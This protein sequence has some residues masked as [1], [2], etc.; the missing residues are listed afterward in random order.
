MTDAIAL[1]RMHSG[2]TD[3]VTPLLMSQDKTV[4]QI[5]TNADVSKASPKK[6]AKLRVTTSFTS[7]CQNSPF[8]INEPVLSTASP[9]GQQ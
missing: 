2:D 1:Q 9:R 8:Y 4:G 6:I 5:G 3:E 7:L